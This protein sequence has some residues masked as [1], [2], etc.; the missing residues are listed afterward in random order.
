MRRKASQRDEG[1]QADLGGGEASVAW[2]RERAVME[3]VCVGRG[4]R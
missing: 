3:A 4:A 1:T 2:G